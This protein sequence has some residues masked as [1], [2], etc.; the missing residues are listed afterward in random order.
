MISLESLGSM[1]AINVPFRWGSLAAFAAMRLLSSSLFSRYNA[2]SLWRRE[3]FAVAI[4]FMLSACCMLWMHLSSTT[5][6]MKEAF[7]QD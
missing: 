1:Q 3:I 5:T 4:L 6:T 7:F 2:F